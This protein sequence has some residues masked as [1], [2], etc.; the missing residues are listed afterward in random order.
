MIRAFRDWFLDQ[1]AIYAAY[2]TDRRNQFTHYVG[3]FLIIFSILIVMD[4]ARL[5]ESL[6]AAVLILGLL[7]L[8]YTM[9]VPAIG[10]LSLIASAPLYLVAESVA[11]TAPVMRWSIVAGCFSVGWAIQFIGHVF[12]RRR[13]AF[14]V[15]MLQVLMAPA[16]LVAEMMFA[17][18]L[19][20]GL[21]R[22]L[23]VRARKY[24]RA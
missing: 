20:R 7:L 8:A 4:Q 6:S 24:A 15:N 23:D 19:Q 9:A 22:E 16:F 3:V 10:I 5:E 14:T 11:A 12:E 2:H 17:A 18:G 13:P 21:A 1:L